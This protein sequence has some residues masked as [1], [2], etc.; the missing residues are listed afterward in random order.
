MISAPIDNMYS[1]KKLTVDQYVFESVAITVS[2]QKTSEFRNPLLAFKF[3]SQDIAL[4][5]NSDYH[6][7]KKGTAFEIPMETPSSVKEWRKKMGGFLVFDK[8]IK[9]NLSKFSNGIC[10]ISMLVFEPLTN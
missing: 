6:F 9:V 5:D 2:K 8:E 4:F 7:G 1:I 3:I 10:V